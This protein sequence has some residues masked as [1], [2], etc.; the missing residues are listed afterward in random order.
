M[1]KTVVQTGKDSM[2]KNNFDTKY[3]ASFNLCHFEA[4]CW[5]NILKMFVVL[6]QNQNKIKPVCG[7]E[8]GFTVYFTQSLLL[9][10]SV[11]LYETS[12]LWDQ[13]TENKFSTLFD[14]SFDSNLKTI[15]H[16][17]H[18]FNKKGKNWK[19]A[20]EI[21]LN[22]IKEFKLDQF[23]IANFLKTDL[24]L[25]FFI[26]N[27]NRYFIGTDYQMKH[28]IFKT[29]KKEWNGDDF[30]NY[31]KSLSSFISAI[32]N[33]QDSYRYNLADLKSNEVMPSIELF[34]Y[35]SEDLFSRVTLKEQTVFRLLLTLYQISYVLLLLKNVL[36]EE[37]VYSEDL[38][39]CFFGKLVSIHYDES[40]D[41]ISNLAEFSSGFDKDIVSILLK[42]IT[43][44]DNF[45]NIRNFARKLRNTIHYED[46]AFDANLTDNN[47]TQSMIRAI[48]LSNSGVSSTEE[49]KQHLTEM[50]EHLE[51]L[52]KSIQEIFRLNKP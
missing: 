4:Y 17:I 40:L 1:A 29:Q 27:K 35:K 48:Y 45:S 42:K 23:S 31:A 16:N 34:D 32:E 7:K 51:I 8:N 24:S 9:N 3:I 39:L 36:D 44:L 10:C 33:S 38:W 11:Y 43:Q 47:S 6:Q 28:I 18:L 13:L 22:K 46:I 26:Q 49:F 15:R 21:I 14:T 25:I 41:N 12:K 20:D 5:L 2:I 30:F 37:F 52:Q 50:L 19:K